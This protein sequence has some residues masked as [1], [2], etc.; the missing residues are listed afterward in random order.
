MRKSFLG[1]TTL[2]IVSACTR[3]DDGASNTADHRIDDVAQSNGLTDLPQPTPNYRE[4]EGDRYLYVSEVSDEEKKRGKAVGDVI[5]YRFLGER[6]GLLVIEEVTESG[7]Q[8][9]KLECRRNCQIMKFTANGQIS[10]IPYGG[11][12]IAGSAMEDAI[13][14]FLEP[15]KA[16]PAPVFA[17]QIPASFIGKWNPELSD[18]GVG[19]NAEAIFVTANTLTFYEA[20]LKVSKVEIISSSR[21]KVSGPLTDEENAVRKMTYTLSLEDG[22]LLVND[23]IARTRCP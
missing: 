6:D 17:A 13:N 15:A 10:R 11:G 19:D 18:C 2:L 1:I 20:L 23:R 14:G 22:Q 9:G 5:E 16:P 8:L 7:V 4:H 3:P 21:V 12:S